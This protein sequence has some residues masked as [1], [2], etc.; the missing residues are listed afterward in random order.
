MYV[1]VA[2]GVDLKGDRMT[3]VSQ[4]LEVVHPEEAG[5]RWTSLLADL[6]FT[7]LRIEAIFSTAPIYQRK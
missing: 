6:R 7:D 5:S 1:V 3:L 2:S 4:A